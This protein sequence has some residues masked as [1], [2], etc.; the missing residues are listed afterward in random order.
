MNRHGVGDRD[1][2]RHLRTLGVSWDRIADATGIPKS[3]VEYMV[4]GQPGR[5]RKADSRPPRQYAC[6]TCG[7]RCAAPDGHPSCSGSARS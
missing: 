3:T 7:T 6:P 1:R 5:T 2:V 4:K